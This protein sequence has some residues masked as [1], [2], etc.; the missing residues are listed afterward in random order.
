M[1][2][3]NYQG[4]VGISQV[5]DYRPTAPV[6]TA[7]SL[8]G[9]EVAEPVYADV[10]A[11]I[12]GCNISFNMFN[13]ISLSQLISDFFG[14]ESYPNLT[15]FDK[16]DQF[17]YEISLINDILITSIED[18]G[19]CDIAEKYNATVVPFFRYFA[20]HPDTGTWGE[21]NDN[22]I[23]TL[24]EIVKVITS[25]QAV[26]EPLMCL[27]RPL[28][29][30]PWIPFDADWLA[31]AYA[32]NRKASP[33]IDKVMSGE[34]LDMMINPVANFRRK[35]EVCT[36]YGPGNNTF[37]ELQQV[38]SFSQI[39]R[40]LD[41]ATRNGNSVV[42]SSVPRPV[43]PNEPR[44]EH[45]DSNASYQEAVDL[46]EIRAAKYNQDIITYKNIQLEIAKAYEPKAAMDNYQA[47]AVRTAELLGPDTQS[48]CNCV[49]EALGLEKQ[50][51][52]YLDIHTSRDVYKMFNKELKVTY[53]QV[54]INDRIHERTD[55]LIFLEKYAQDESKLSRIL[56]EVEPARRYTKVELTDGSLTVKHPYST[57]FSTTPDITYK[58]LNADKKVYVSNGWDIYQ[59]NEKMLAQIRDL[60]LQKEDI[61][62]KVNQRI[63]DDQDHFS[64]KTSLVSKAMSDGATNISE[65]TG[66]ESIDAQATYNEAR[67]LYDSYFS[68]WTPFNIERDASDFRARSSYI[69]PSDMPQSFNSREYNPD[70]F[71]V[72]GQAATDAKIDARTQTI[73]FDNGIVQKDG[74]ISWRTNNP[75]NLEY[76]EFTQN[77]GA[78]NYLVTDINYNE[79]TRYIAIFP[80]I[81][82]GIQTAINYIYTYYGDY[83]I[84]QLS[85]V[86]KPSYSRNDVY[87]RYLAQ[88][89]QVQR[90]TP[91][92]LLGADS[93]IRL[94]KAIASYD[95]AFEVGS[96]WADGQKV[97][98]VPFIKNISRGEVQITF[99]VMNNLPH[100]IQ[101]EI[102]NQLQF[103][104]NIYSDV[105]KSTLELEAIDNAIM[106]LEEAIE[107]SAAARVLF[108]RDMPIPCTC[109]DFVCMLIQTVIS[110]I[111]ALF[112]ELLA[113][114]GQ[115]LIKYLI[116]DSV[117]NLIRLVMEK[118]KCI[119]QL[120]TID[121]TLRIIDNAAEQL[122]E[123]LRY[124][125]ALY[126]SDTCFLREA[127]DPLAEF[128]PSDP[129]SDPAFPGDPWANTP[130]VDWKPDDIS[131]GLFPEDDLLN[132]PTVV[133]ELPPIDGGFVPPTII[134][135]PPGLP[136]FPTPGNFKD[137]LRY[138]LPMTVILTD[139]IKVHHQT[140]N[141]NIPIL[142][143]DCGTENAD[144]RYG[145]CNQRL[146]TDI[147]IEIIK[148]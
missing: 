32:Y 73:Y 70:S 56:K 36:G 55:N 129:Y 119:F 45:Y 128:G 108:M 69:D 103:R 5:H 97:P 48:I 110:Y 78:I 144:T 121:E 22:F 107:E 9:A 16:A 37:Y 95:D 34:V 80:D 91:I 100:Y 39:K 147:T 47:A 33:Y 99:D 101:T 131:G 53:D 44:P 29:G 117:R 41:V 124:R 81:D 148:V 93:R 64:K 87:A 19:C 28:P 96:I 120:F 6:Y 138:G 52:E 20:D 74:S 13:G 7:G 94:I 89:L 105:Y 98:A 125:V 68:G 15:L 82:T 43:R 65:M 112:N 135:I 1:S 84:E 63:L 25:I 143:F 118:V 146:Q 71:E 133:E 60:K 2:S 42:A 3:F 51:P 116:P 88:E 24:I 114:L 58:T 46:Y 4:F 111:L 27:I 79:A 38:G 61:L 49:T 130:G 10:Q 142:E 21:G 141:A 106:V 75:L 72:Q 11:N 109:A 14:L 126:P 134:D 76:G 102:N 132:E 54:N 50:I 67:R 104:G 145:A 59:N 57:H 85:D 26:V 77:S 35:L 86:V 137:D 127:I 92:S 66:Q 122:L 83:T 140:E 30:N 113:Y 62:R 136:T 123:D 18:M 139:G 17:S 90:T 8:F 23:S 115:L 12:M 31:W 40:L